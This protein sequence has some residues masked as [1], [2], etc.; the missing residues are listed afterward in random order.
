MAKIAGR[1]EGNSSWFVLRVLEFLDILHL[2][3][4]V[5]K[6]SMHFVCCEKST[7][8]PIWVPCYAIMIMMKGLT[9]IVKGGSS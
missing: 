1:E 7:V 4:A 3:L 2:M 6:R 8:R 5:L 9:R